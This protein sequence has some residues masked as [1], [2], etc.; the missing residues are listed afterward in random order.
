MSAKLYDEKT[1]HTTRVLSKGRKSK[2]RLEEKSVGTFASEGPCCSKTKEGRYKGTGVYCFTH[3]TS[4]KKYIGSSE[5]CHS[6]RMSHEY[7]IKKGN[8][9]KFHRQAAKLGLESFSFSIIEKCK[10][11]IRHEREKFWIEKLQSVEPNGFNLNVPQSKNHLALKLE[12]RLHTLLRKA[13]TQ[14]GRTL[15]RQA[16]FIIRTSLAELLASKKP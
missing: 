8:G 2:I 10:N 5:D 11:D 16:E 13:A 15:K 14:E 12:P 3:T 7:A 6:R 4:G 1:N 9:Q